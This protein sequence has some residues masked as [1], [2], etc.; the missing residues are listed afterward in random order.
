MQST[1]IQQ[2]HH[3]TQLSSSAKRVVV[4]SVKHISEEA[5]KCYTAGVRER[6][7]KQIWNKPTDI[8]TRE[9]WGGG[10]LGTEAEFL[11]QGLQK[12]ALKQVF[13]K[14][15][16]G[17]IM[18]EQMSTLQPVKDL[19]LQEMEM[20]P[21]K[22]Q[23]K[24]TPC[25]NRPLQGPCSWRG[26]HAWFSG[27]ICDPIEDRH[28]SNLFLKDCNSLQEPMLEQSLKSC[29]LLKGCLSVKDYLLWEESHTGVEESTKGK[30]QQRKLFLLQ[31]PFRT[32]LAPLWVRREEVEELWTEE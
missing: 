8:S 17:T 26:A 4:L 30:E 24:E 15:S 31:P 19:M 18:L 9:A 20:S 21:R 1:W 11:L 25:H 23:P 13:P 3:R 12:D 10:T 16:M 27:R 7:D 32:L 5:K 2:T 14:Q 29:N 6:C 28:W 22:M